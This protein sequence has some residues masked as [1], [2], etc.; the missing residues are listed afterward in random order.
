[1]ERISITKSFVGDGVRDA[2]R[3]AFGALVRE[4]GPR[5]VN[6]RNATKFTAEHHVA[7]YA[8]KGPREDGLVDGRPSVYSGTSSYVLIVSADLICDERVAPIS[9]LIATHTTNRQ[10]V[11]R[12][13]DAVPWADKRRLIAVS[14]AIISVSHY[15]NLSVRLLLPIWKYLQ[16]H[17]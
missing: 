17:G 4:V 8:I 13:P 15:L 1:M 10:A 6:K 2:R 14:A 11:A 7:L 5:H 3:S 12:S 16:I 9:R